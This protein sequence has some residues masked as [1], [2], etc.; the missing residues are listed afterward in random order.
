MRW[1]L[2]GIL[3]LVMTARMATAA[4]YDDF[5]RGIS[6]NEI[7][8]SDAAIL[9][10]T[11]A[12]TA[13]D[14]PQAYIPQAYIGRAT[15]YLREKK[16]AMAIADLDQAIKLKPDDLYAYRMRAASNACA[17][18]PAAA[19]ADLSAAAHMRPSGENFEELA[20]MQ[21]DYGFFQEAAES[22][23]QAETL[24]ANDKNKLPYLILWKA[25]S[26][27]RAG[28]LDQIDLATAISQLSS[29]WPVPLLSLFA[30]KMTV[31]EVYRAAANRDAKLAGNQ[32]CEADFYIGE[33]RLAR[34]DPAAAKALLQQALS[35]CPHDF[36]E[37][38]YA[39]TEL[40]RQP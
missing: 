28:L 25:M 14:L 20:R 5:S 40:K 16:C 18:R 12:L 7:G 17:D 29:D 15:A 4:A 3:A 26:A 19:V 35:E 1:I 37:Y 36:V 31:E 32:K 13:G 2:V 10:F 23:A 24:S 22:Y 9:S 21:W 39:Q 6:A 34:K 11:N 8:D 38:S 27:D 33:W 30:G